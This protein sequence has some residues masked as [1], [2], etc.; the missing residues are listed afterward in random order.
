LDPH[1]TLKNA[2]YQVNRVAQK[3]AK[4]TNRA[5]TQVR[6]EIT[7]LLR[8]KVEAPLRGLVGVDLVNVLEV[9]LALQ[10]RFGTLP[11]ASK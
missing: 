8:E 3:W 2:L 4:D 6:Q 11:G 10:S 7:D 9:N 5:E 1:I